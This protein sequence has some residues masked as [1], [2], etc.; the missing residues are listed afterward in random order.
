MKHLQIIFK[1]LKIN[2]IT[3]Y[4]KLKKNLIILMN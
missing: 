1:S 3:L 2:K 4:K